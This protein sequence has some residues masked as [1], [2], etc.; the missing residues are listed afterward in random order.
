VGLSIVDAVGQSASLQTV[1]GFVTRGSG[2]SIHRDDCST[3]MA[4]GSPD[5]RVI[6]VEG[7]TC[8]GLAYPKCSQ[9][10]GLPGGRGTEAAGQVVLR[11]FAG[12]HL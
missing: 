4:N 3:H 1:F 2:V 9:C 8:L 6:E 10:S 12:F 5:Y 11:I 7:R